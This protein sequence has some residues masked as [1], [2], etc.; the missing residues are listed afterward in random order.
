MLE[1]LHACMVARR[2][3]RTDTAVQILRYRCIG[4][5]IQ[6]YFIKHASTRGITVYLYAPR[7]LLELETYFLLA[8]DGISNSLN[9]HY[10]PVTLD[11]IRQN[12]SW[13]SLEPS[14]KAGPGP[15]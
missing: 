2:R 8:Q 13:A 9:L 11:H 1:Q 3:A 15:N 12:S 6:L 4:I 5:K 10:R 14:R 7:S